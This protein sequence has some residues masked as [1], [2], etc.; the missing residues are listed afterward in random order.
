M[1]T[2]LDVHDYIIGAIASSEDPEYPVEEVLNNEPREYWRALSA[3][4]TLELIIK[5]GA[6]CFGLSGINAVTVNVSVG[7]AGKGFT[8]GDEDSFS[9]PDEDS[10]DLYEAIDA[11]FTAEYDL[12]DTGVGTL[13]VTYD[14]LVYQH[15]ATIELITAE[16]PAQTAI[17]R[18]GVQ[19]EFNQP[20]RGIGEG[21]RSNDVVTLMRSGASDIDPG[22]PRA[23]RT[24]QF[25]HLLL[26]SD[27]YRFLHTIFLRNGMDPLF[28]RVV[29]SETETV[30]ILYAMPDGALPGGNHAYH[31]RKFVDTT[32]IEVV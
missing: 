30:W 14:D 26:R 13:L 11:N 18:A 9:I 7:L 6:T 21:L 22:N 2:V 5:G 23:V 4:A 16:D 19:S 32:I 27:F 3:M 29:D 20:H 17:A 24:F 1:T 12:S 8:L 10:F 25:R 31:S 15:V 28:W